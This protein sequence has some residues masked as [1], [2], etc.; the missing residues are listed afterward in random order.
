MPRGDWLL[1]MIVGGVFVL[2]GVVAMWWAHREEQRYYTALSHRPDVREYLE[3]WPPR[4]EPGA[5]RIGG[6][7]AVAVGLVLVGL[8]GLFLLQK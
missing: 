5:L 4:V 8:G 7:V 3:H 2:L 6:W 1:F